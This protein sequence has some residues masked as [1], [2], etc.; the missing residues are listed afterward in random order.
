M[1]QFDDQAVVLKH[2][3]GTRVF[4]WGLVLGFLPTAS[5]G[6][7]L[8]LRPFS[9][10]GMHTVMQIHI[11]GAWVLSLA[12][13][14]FF[15]FQY[16]RVVSFW[17]EIF[18]WTKNDV[19]WMKVQGGY[20]QKIFLGKIVPVPAMRKM[21]SGQK[22][23]GIIVFFGVILIAVSGWILYAALP[24]VPKEIAFYADKMHLILGLFITFC[25][26]FGHIILGIYN[27]KEFVCMFGDGTM[28]VS[29]AAHHNALWVN[30]D[31]EV[32]KKG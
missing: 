23:L 7:A 24:A 27:W 4:H 21:N 28:Q 18:T 12:C 32:V 31:I 5:T 6:I 2:G 20:P 15:L 14:Y 19:E 1:A 13:I 29:E 10:A 3:L 8:W 9:G 11:I 26:V 25:V 30:E 16:K 22:M 17:R